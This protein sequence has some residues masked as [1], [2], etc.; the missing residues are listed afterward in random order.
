MLCRLRLTR[1]IQTYIKENDTHQQHE[2]ILSN[3]T[4]IFVIMRFVSTV[5]TA[6]LHDSVSSNC[7]VLSAVSFYSFQPFALSLF[8]LLSNFFQLYY[9]YWMSINVFI[10][11]QTLLPVSALLS[12][13]Y[14]SILPHPAPT[15]LRPLLLSPWSV[16]SGKT[17][18]AKV[19]NIWLLCFLSSRI[20][21]KPLR[22]SL[23]AMG[24]RLLMCCFFL[25]LRSFCFKKDLVFNFTRN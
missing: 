23:D 8:S 24:G 10:F 18:S 15:V 22:F 11:S 14:V 20:N 1:W 3:N 17:K 4:A 12:C 9:L 16:P 6:E 7:P 21:P 2:L 5:E 25:Q 13:F 19:T